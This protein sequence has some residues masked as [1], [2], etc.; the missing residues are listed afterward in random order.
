MLIRMKT[1]VNIRIV[2]AFVGFFGGFALFTL[3]QMSG[4][5]SPID[6]AL[7]FASIFGG[8]F[9]L[10]WIFSRLVAAPCPLCG[11]AAYSTLLNPTRYRCSGCG[12]TPDAG[13][14]YAIESM[15]SAPLIR[16]DSFLMKAVPGLNDGVVFIMLGIAAIAGGLFFGAESLEL[17]RHGVTTEA[18]VAK[19]DMRGDDASGTRDYRATIIYK[20]GDTDLALERSWSVKRGGSCWWPCFHQG[21]KL[22]VRYLPAEPGKAAVYSLFDLFLAPALGFL[23]GIVFIFGGWVTGREIRRRSR[24]SKLEL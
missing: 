2:L 15:D 14:T 6:F 18:R 16:S 5:H 13:V 4:R 8:G 21:E 10:Q 20:V 19:V 23:I 12:R 22:K 7:F 1:H 24:R 9:L 17:L 3:Y 11:G